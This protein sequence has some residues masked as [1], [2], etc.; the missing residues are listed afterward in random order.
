MAK[1]T[2]AQKDEMVAALESGTP[3]KDIM[4]KYGVSDVTVYNHRTK[5]NNAKPKRR[6]GRTTKKVSNRPTAREIAL[7]KENRE[8]KDK[9]LALLLK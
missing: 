2:K 1:Y 3:I 7:E 8:L 6:G 5:L 4:E 9:L